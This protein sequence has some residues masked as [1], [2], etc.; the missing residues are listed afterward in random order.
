MS[1]IRDICSASLYVV[2]LEV[3]LL[4]R[5]DSACIHIKESK[6]SEEIGSVSKKVRSGACAVCWVSSPEGRVGSLLIL[7][8]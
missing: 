3:R 8:K 2:E 4:I 7:E 5:S 6:R 1:F